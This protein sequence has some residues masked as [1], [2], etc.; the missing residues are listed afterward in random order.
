MKVLKAF[1]LLGV[2]LLGLVVLVW[3]GARFHDGPLAMFPGGPLEAG[4]LVEI[5]V[6]D[7][8][9]AASV[10]EIEMQLAD[11]TTSR[12]VWIVTRGKR[13]FIPCSLRF[14]PGK[15][16]HQ[17]AVKDGRAYLR[18]DGKRYPVELRRLEGTIPPELEA[19]M[20]EKYGSGPPGD[21]TWL[22]EVAYRT[23]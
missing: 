13:A 14:P 12:T 1:G 22:F 16:W 7:W 2:G 11:D 10:S 21:G 18:I 3:L 19:V 15:R 8:G 4:P 5:P 17:R 23:G 9:F 20:V 6:T